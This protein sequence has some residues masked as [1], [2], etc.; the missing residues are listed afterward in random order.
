MR[1][2]DDQTAGCKLPKPGHES[3]KAASKSVLGLDDKVEMPPRWGAE[4]R[5][6]GYGREP[7]NKT[8]PSRLE[9]S[10]DMGDMTVKSKA[11]P[12]ISEEKEASVTSDD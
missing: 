4:L 8:A 9:T 3:A 6:A 1:S 7:L 10:W 11:R 2:F 5:M 12:I